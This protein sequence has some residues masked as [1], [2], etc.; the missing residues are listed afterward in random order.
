ML[1]AVKANTAA[2]ATK[3]IFLIILYYL[4]VLDDELLRL[5][6]L[7]D[8]ALR[9]VELLLDE[10]LRLLELLD[11]ALF[12]ELDVLDERDEVDDDE[13]VVVAVPDFFTRLW[14]VDVEVEE[15]LLGVLVV[16]DDVRLGVEVV[17]DVV[18][19]GV[20]VVVDEVRLGVEV[21]VEEA[22]LGVEVVVAV[23]LVVLSRLPDV[24]EGAEVVV[25][26][27]AARASRTVRALAVDPAALTAGMVAVR[28]A[29]VFSG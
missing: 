24:D 9:L 1:Q 26:V 27:A 7:P 16:V 5:V 15:D 2:I 6:E 13:R 20:L 19:L 10:E 25:W 14:V 22:R 29:K 8:E 23:R 12:V 4:R 18:R 11:G 28:F 17:V 21:V 3:Y